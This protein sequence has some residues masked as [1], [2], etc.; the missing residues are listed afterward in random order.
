MRFTRGNLTE[1][2]VAVLTG[3][4]L[5]GA[6]ASIKTNLNDCAAKNPGAA[7]SLEGALGCFTYATANTFGISQFVGNT[8]VA[9]GEGRLK[10]HG[11]QP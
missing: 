1:L 5:V 11:V 7:T 2:S 3:A 10:P 4:L 8:L 9:M 6:A